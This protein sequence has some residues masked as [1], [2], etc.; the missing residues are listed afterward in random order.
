M[1]QE[2]EGG[3][4][5]TNCVLSVVVVVGVDVDERVGLEGECLSRDEGVVVE[6]MDARRWL[7]RSFKM[8]RVYE[9]VQYNPTVHKVH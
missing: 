8:K 4:G 6:L 2:L 5:V 9:D 3:D 7:V 1:V